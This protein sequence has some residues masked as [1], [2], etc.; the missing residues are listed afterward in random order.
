M[1]CA[2]LVALTISG[3]KKDPQEGGV[4]LNI[5]HL[6]ETETL[7]F[8]DVKYT[9]AAGHNYSVSQ[10]KYYISNVVLTAD[11]GSIHKVNTPFYCDGKNA[12]S[13]SL[14]LGT[15]PTGTYNTVSFVFGLDAATNKPNA[16]SNTLGR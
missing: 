8:D 11:D 7:S 15:V 13:L 2:V 6:V 4:T 14:D 12:T 5:N 10:L 16:L 1:I 9:L 3:C